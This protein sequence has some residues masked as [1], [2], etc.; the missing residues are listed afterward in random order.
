MIIAFHCQQL[1]L[2]GT[3][4]ATYDYAHYNEE[5]LKNISII[6][7]P[8]NS[9]SGNKLAEDKFKSRFKVIYYSNINEIDELLLENNVELFYVLKAGFNDSI[10]S[11]KIKTC[12]HV[13]FR[14]NDPHGNKYAYISEWLAKDVGN[15]NFPYVPHIVTLPSH[16]ENL[17]SKLGIPQNS[18]VFGRYGGEDTFDIT[19]VKKAIYKLAKQNPDIYF[20]FMNTENFVLKRKYYSKRWK[21]KY[22]AW[23]TN[24]SKKIKNIIFLDGQSDMIEKVKFINTSD[25]MIHAR[26]DGETFGLACGEFSIKNKPVITCNHS[27]VKDRSHIEILGKKGIFYHDEKSFTESIRNFDKYKSANYD[28]YSEIFSPE[29][30]MMKFKTVFID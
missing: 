5:I 11:T 21:N 12:V 13:V 26:W 15:N 2:R 23:F 18:R 20:I 9:K 3:E 6:I 24:P 16:H 30:V 14:Y 8:L 25:A 1:G 29:N 22:I 7:T 17:R 28:A 10:F 27:K 19:F 4:V